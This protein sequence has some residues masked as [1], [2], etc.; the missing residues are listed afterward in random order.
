MRGAARVLVVNDW[1]RKR[2][3]RRDHQHVLQTWH[4][5]MLKRLAL[6]RTDR[7]LRTRIA[8]R[9]E[10]KRW[11]ALLAQNSYSA[12]I[13]RSAYGHRGPIWEEGYPRNDVFDQ[14]RPRSRDPDRS[15]GFRTAS[16]SCC[17]HRPGATIAPR[18][19]TTST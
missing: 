3:R 17:T 19:S 1:L 16:G 6:D 13:F 11:D 15:W 12:G 10:D 18:W 9:R 4:G 2:Y 14:T 5:T 8:I 7:G